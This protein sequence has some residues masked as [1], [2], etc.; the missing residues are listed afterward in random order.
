MTDVTLM[1]QIMCT[2][3][4]IHGTHVFKL[5]VYTAHACGGAHAKRRLAGVPPL[6]ETRVSFLIFTS[7][8]HCPTFLLT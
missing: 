4:H 7:T 6:S 1:S 5:S 2:I 3:A 8:I